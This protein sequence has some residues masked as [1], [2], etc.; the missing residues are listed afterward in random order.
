MTYILGI[1]PGVTGA[2]AI[3]TSKHKYIKVCELF[4]NFETVLEDITP[5]RTSLAACVEKVASMPNQGVKSTATFL[6][7]AGAWEGFLTALEIPYTLVPPQT[8]QRSILDTQT[9]KK[10]TTST[11]PKKIRKEQAANKRLRK[12]HI[13]AFVLRHLPKSKKHFK[14]K[15]DQDKADALC[16]AL[17]K[18]KQMGYKG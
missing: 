10:P 6:K 18:R 12:L 8:W 13:T 2:Y 14:L 15:K 3:L 5:Y 16:I 7:N 9:P 4:T 1:D 17:Y 11:D